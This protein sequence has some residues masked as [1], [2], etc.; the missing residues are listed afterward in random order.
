MQYAWNNCNRK[1][2]VVFS[3]KKIGPVIS[4][5]TVLSPRIH[6]KEDR[7]GTYVT[8]LTWIVK[9]NYDDEDFF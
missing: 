1:C 7:V 3:L 5:N 8:Q 6:V 2:L 4:F 9:V